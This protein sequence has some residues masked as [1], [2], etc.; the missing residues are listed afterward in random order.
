[1]GGLSLILKKALIEDSNKD[2]SDPDSCQNVD[3]TAD[4]VQAQGELKGRPAHTRRRQ[5]QLG[6]GRVS[7]PLIPPSSRQTVDVCN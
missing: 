5:R 6:E 4:T 2:T 7:L 1:M 3:E